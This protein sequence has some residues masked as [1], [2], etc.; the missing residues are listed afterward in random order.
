MTLTKMIEAGAQIPDELDSFPEIGTM[1]FSD[2]FKAWFADRE[3]FTDDVATFSTRWRLKALTVA[4]KWVP[5]LDKY[6]DIINGFVTPSE[7][8]LEKVYAA[9]DGNVSTAY[10]T[11]MISRDRSGNGD[12]D[13]QRLIK[14]DEFANYWD[15]MLSDFEPLFRGVYIV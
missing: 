1:Q 11:G 4:A 12:E 2:F 6:A 3:T 8:E 7:T 13:P 9:P 15:E 10:V 14:V 5:L